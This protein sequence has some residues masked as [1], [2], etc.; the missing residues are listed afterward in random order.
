MTRTRSGSIL[1]PDG[2]IS[3]RIAYDDRIVGIEGAATDAPAAPYILPGFVDLHVHGGGGADMMQGE[4]A[5][6]QSARLHAR[7]GTTAMLATTITAPADETIAAVAAAGAVMANPQPGEA[8]LLGVHLEGPFINPGRLGA[9]PAFAVPPDLALL[10]RL[11]ACAP[12]R[13]ITIAPEC[14]PDGR[15]AEAVH[16]AG[17]K[18]QIGHTLCDYACA[19]AHLLD[20]WGVTHLYNAMSPFSQRASSL[21]GAALAHADYAE[22][23]PDLIHVD[24]G[25]LLAA[26]RA[27]PNL[28]GV[29]DATAGAGMPDGAY[30]LGSHRVTKRDGAMR[31]ADGTLAGSSLTMDQ[32]LRNLVGLGLALADAARRLSAIPADWLGQPDVGRLSVGAHADILELD[33]DLA[34]TDVSLGGRPHSELTKDN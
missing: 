29:T 34:L 26:H 7:H 3:G 31:L 13:V 22:I 33:G 16:A 18:A 12:V 28:Y 9:Q 25:A 19:R 30:R 24:A 2:W 32:A 1:T 14:D 6:R 10:A 5:I 23:I 27:I 20:G 21:I 17:I 11:G 15:L 4:A 8:R